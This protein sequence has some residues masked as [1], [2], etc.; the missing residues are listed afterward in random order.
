MVQNTV[1]INKNRFKYLAYY[2]GR[3]KELFEFNKLNKINLSDY[4]RTILSYNEIIVEKL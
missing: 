2:N 3:L 4:F 1:K